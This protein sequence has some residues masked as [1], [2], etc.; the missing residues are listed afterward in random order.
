MLPV[1]FHLPVAL[2]KHY[3]QI[4]IPPAVG[5]HLRPG[6]IR[7]VAEH[8]KKTRPRIVVVWIGLDSLRHR[9]LLG[10]VSSVTWFLWN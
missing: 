10:A 7:R 2:L 4:R 9:L 3:P 6:R 8:Q 5:W 1:S